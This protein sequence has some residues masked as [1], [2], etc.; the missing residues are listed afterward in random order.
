MKVFRSLIRFPVG[1][2]AFRT[3]FEVKICDFLHLK[4]GQGKINYLQFQ[5]RVNIWSKTNY[6]FAPEIGYALN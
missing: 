5:L 1:E 3:E 6:D 2:K 4:F